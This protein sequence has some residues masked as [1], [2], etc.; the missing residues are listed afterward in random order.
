MR[1]GGRDPR[2][3]EMDNPPHLAKNQVLIEI[4]DFRS[5]YRP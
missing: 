4:S 2:L 1:E 3:Q 5:N